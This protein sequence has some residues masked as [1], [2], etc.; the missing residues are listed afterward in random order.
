MELLAAQGRIVAA[1]MLFIQSMTGTV[2]IDLPAPQI[3][4]IPQSELAHKACG[5][6]P[7][8]VYGW[9]SNTDKRVYLAQGQDFINDPHARSVLL[10]E[11]VHYTQDKMKTPTMINSCLTWKA[12]ELQ[13]YDIQYEWLRRQHVRV[14][15][16]SFNAVLIHFENIRCPYG[17]TDAEAPSTH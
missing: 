8:N 11:L 10:H 14:T 16:P 6:T 13:A 5:G 2:G 15:T 7:C 9:F 4:V 17:K 12:R 1:L 3:H